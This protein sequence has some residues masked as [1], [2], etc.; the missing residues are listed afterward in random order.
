MAGTCQYSFDKSSPYAMKNYIKTRHFQI[1]S[2][3]AGLVKSHAANHGLV[4]HW[5][6]I[7]FIS[8]QSWVCK[9]KWLNSITSYIKTSVEKNTLNDYLT[10][11]KK[12]NKKVPCCFVV[13]MT[14][15]SH[16]H[17]KCL[18][19]TSTAKNDRSRECI[20]LLLFNIS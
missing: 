6:T 16:L 20:M 15:L 10:L 2:F 13:V 12:C 7:W 17:N 9:K 8:H 5:V 4:I 11:I 1:N 19:F 14:A 18:N 3:I